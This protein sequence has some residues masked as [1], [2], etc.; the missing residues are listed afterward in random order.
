MCCNLIILQCADNIF[1]PQIQAQLSPHRDS[2]TP[3]PLQMK[4]ARKEKVHNFTSWN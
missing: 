4:T 3:A 1:S 2:H